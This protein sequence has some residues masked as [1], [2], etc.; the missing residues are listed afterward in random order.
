MRPLFLLLLTLFFLLPT[1]S[2]KQNV[3]VSSTSRIEWEGENGSI[4]SSTFSEDM[5]PIPA[6]VPLWLVSVFVNNGNSSYRINYVNG[7]A[8]RLVYSQSPE[9]FHSQI[10]LTKERLT[11]LPI[12]FDVDPGAEVTID[13]PWRTPL[14]AFH[15]FPLEATILVEVSFTSNGTDAKLTLLDYKRVTFRADA[16]AAATTTDSNFLTLLYAFLIALATMSPALFSLSWGDTN[17]A[18]ARARKEM[19]KKKM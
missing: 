17:A 4:E 18:C 14:L 12:N 9:S 7:F 2:V 5:R 3:S 13:Y 19:M 11:Y 8:T 10:N 15:E 6:G 1:F 16:A